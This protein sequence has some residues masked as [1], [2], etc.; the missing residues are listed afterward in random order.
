MGE[1]PVAG[2]SV[3]A[4]TQTGLWRGCRDIATGLKRRRACFADRG[5]V[6]ATGRQERRRILAEV[7]GRDV[8]PSERRTRRQ[9]AWAAAC[10]LRA[11]RTPTRMT[12]APSSL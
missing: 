12:I 3:I 5:N 1:Q 6:G 8:R 4:K 2:E 10:R 11:V 7:S 9:A